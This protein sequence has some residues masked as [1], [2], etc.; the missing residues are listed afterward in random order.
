[1]P[2]S[3]SSATSEQSITKEL[4]EC[5]YCQKEVQIRSLFHH[6]RVHH[7]TD[8]LENT[9]RKWIE[10]AEAGHPLKMTFTFGYDEEL[11][12]W[13][14]LEIYGC[15]SSDKTF[16]TEER[17]LRHFKHNPQHLKEHNKQI[18]KLKKE[19]E[20]M[21][22]R[23][24]EE[25]IKKQQ[26]NPI[27]YKRTQGFN[28]ADPK[29]KEGLWRGILHWKKAGDLGI[30]LGNYY[31][32]DEYEFSPT[33]SKPDRILWKDAVE[34]F[35]K[36]CSHAKKLLDNP[37]EQ[38]YLKKLRI[39]HQYFNSFYYGCKDNL[40]K[41]GN[42]DPRLDPKYPECI[43]VEDV[44]KM[45]EDYFYYATEDMP[46]PTAQDLDPVIQDMKPKPVEPKPEPPKPKLPAILPMLNASQTQIFLNNYPPGSAEWK[47][48][49]TTLSGKEA[50]P[51]EAKIL[52]QAYHNYPKIISNSKVKRGAMPKGKTVQSTLVQ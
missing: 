45:D 14:T 6:I 18:K 3:I 13:K 21:K 26:A 5:P 42:L 49:F 15:L 8:F 44:H 29:F 51:E 52:E 47:K 50:M 12:H 33:P 2:G 17:G 39:L 34:K 10:V 22:K 16:A 7:I 23:D 11:D 37:T 20:A 43:V 36:M 40:E 31:L 19:F 41:E 28:Q 1:M 32:G 25:R 27:F 46:I 4:K 9:K 48:A 24:E 38:D 30:S 35:K